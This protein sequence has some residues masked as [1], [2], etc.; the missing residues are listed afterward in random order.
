[1]KLIKVLNL[2]PHEVFI[3]LAVKEAPDREECDAIY[4]VSPRTNF[5][6][7]FIIRIEDL[8]KL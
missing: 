5:K 3:S 4:T 1:M 8:I 7:I 6:P 2:H